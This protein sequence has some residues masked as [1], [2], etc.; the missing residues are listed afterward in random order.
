[1]T[2]IGEWAVGAAVLIGAALWRWKVPIG[3]WLIGGAASPSGDSLA[4]L[5]RAVLAEIEAKRIESVKG[6]VEAVIRERLDPSASKN[7]GGGAE[8]KNPDPGAA[9]PKG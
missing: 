3:G 8:P 7:P 6:D 2:G 1:M 5:I 4:A 9:G